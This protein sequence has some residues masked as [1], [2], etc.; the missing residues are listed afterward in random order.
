MVSCGMEV[1]EMG[2]GQG[3]CGNDKLSRLRRPREAL[4]QDRMPRCG[5][6]SRGKDYDVAD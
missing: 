2:L 5:S 1:S 6:V 3:G 4:F